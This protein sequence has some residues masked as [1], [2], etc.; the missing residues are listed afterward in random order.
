[1]KKEVKI[2]PELESL[3]KEA[4]KY[5]SAEEFVRGIS[6]ATKGDIYLARKT[7]KAE[8]LEGA[9]H[10][11]LDLGKETQAGKYLK[12]LESETDKIVKNFYTQATK[13]VKPIVKLKVKPEVKPIPKEL[14][15]LA[16]EKK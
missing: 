13:E 3:A 8:Q 5:K 4:R 14:E 15:P 2:S 6:S 11:A 16:K 12:Q 7:T 9:Y 10:K 1:M